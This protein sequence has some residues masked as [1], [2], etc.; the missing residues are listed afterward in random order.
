[1]NGGEKNALFSFVLSWITV[2]TEVDKK[3]Y[4]THLK[5]HPVFGDTITPE[6]RPSKSGKLI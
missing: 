2:E 1:M 5:M 4:E 6:G 3:W